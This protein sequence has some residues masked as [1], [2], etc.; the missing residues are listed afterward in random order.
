MRR[1][2]FLIHGIAFGTLRQMIADGFQDSRARGTRNLIN[3]GVTHELDL[4][5][6]H[7]SRKVLASIGRRSRTLVHAASGGAT[8]ANKPATFPIFPPRITKRCSTRN[9]R[10]HNSYNR[11]RVITAAHNW[12][13]TRSPLWPAGRASCLSLLDPSVISERKY[14][15]NSGISILTGQ[16]SRQAPH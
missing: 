8:R 6:R 9:V 12:K 11:G 2:L 3:H 1:L 13:A 7:C 16:T 15:S 10:L 5:F 4:S 14:K